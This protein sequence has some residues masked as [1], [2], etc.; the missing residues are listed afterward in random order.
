MMTKFNQ[1]YS[2]SSV[3]A[4]IVFFYNGTTISPDDTPLTVRNEFT[5]VFVLL[6]IDDESSKFNS[7]YCSIFVRS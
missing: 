5:G 1:M 7:N 4:T 2:R 6:F 3:G